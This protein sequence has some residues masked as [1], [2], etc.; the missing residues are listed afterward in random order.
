MAIDINPVARKSDLVV[1]E[2][3]GEFLVFDLVTNKAHS[4]NES[5]SVVWKLC[6]GSRS[7]PELRD[8]FSI[9]TGKFVSEE[10]ISLAIDQL[11]EFELLENPKAFSNSGIS[12]RN[13]IRKVGLASMA[14]LPVVSMLAFPNPA[15]ANTCGTSVCGDLPGTC[16]S[17][18]TYCCRGTCTPSQG[19][20]GAPCAPPGNFKTKSDF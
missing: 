1:Q 4:L 18:T 17:G 20:C 10:F 16:P 15:L 6:D 12:R 5:A 13:L 11:G 2:L 19:A 9:Q 3:D 7:V 14:A 8:I